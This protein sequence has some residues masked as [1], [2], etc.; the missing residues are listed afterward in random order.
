MFCTSVCTINSF[1]FMDTNSTDSTHCKQ[2][3]FQI[4]LREL[5][6]SADE[7][8]IY[9]VIVIVE[10]VL[11]VIALVICI[12]LFMEWKKQKNL[13]VISNVIKTD[14]KEKTADGDGANTTDGDGANTTDGDGANTTV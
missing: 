6:Q 13:N 14:T 5:E 7:I 10:A 12:V 1:V 11:L 3:D 8:R 2:S 4:L 9:L